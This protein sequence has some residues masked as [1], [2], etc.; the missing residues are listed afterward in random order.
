MLQKPKKHIFNNL[1]TILPPSDC[2]L[3]GENT[4]PLS[5][6]IFQSLPKHSMQCKN[7]RLIK[8]ILMEFPLLYASVKINK[9]AF[10]YVKFKNK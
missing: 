2:G 9:K 6:I 10:I 3:L 8:T 7:T 1:K 4:F 5:A